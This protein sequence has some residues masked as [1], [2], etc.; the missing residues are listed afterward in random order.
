MRLSTT[1]R[2]WAGCEAAPGTSPGTVISRSLPTCSA[3]L[4]GRSRVAAFY[5]WESL[6]GI[7]AWGVVASLFL[8]AESGHNYHPPCGAP[9]GH[10]KL[11]PHQS[12]T[13]EIFLYAM[14]QGSVRFGWTWQDV[15]VCSLGLGPPVLCELCHNVL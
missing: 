3:A 14:S 5:M 10:C 4:S 1:T 12:I 8:L 13:S 11:Q 15:L 9:C 6:K 7:D 2:L